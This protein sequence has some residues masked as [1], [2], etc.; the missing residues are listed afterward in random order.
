MSAEPQ[1][2]GLAQYVAAQMLAFREV[3]LAADEHFFDFPENV[4]AY[5][6]F[7]QALPY[8]WVNLQSRQPL[9]GAFLVP[10]SKVTQ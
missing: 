3:V 4:V 7:V 8:V 5:R 10:G 9:V 1:T 2:T 6:D